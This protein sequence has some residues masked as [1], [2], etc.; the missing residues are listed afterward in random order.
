M[1]TRAG[2]SSLLVSPTSG[3]IIRPSTSSSAHL[4]R[5]S[6]ARWMGLRVWNATTLF[7]PRCLNSVR[8]SRGVR[9]RSLAKSWVGSSSTVT[10]P[11]T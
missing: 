10:L 4:V 3:W 11:A 6:W 9:R 2:T 7:Q 5:Y 8:V 1:R